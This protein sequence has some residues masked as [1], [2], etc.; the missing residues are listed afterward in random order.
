MRAGGVSVICFV[1]AGTFG[2]H[3]PSSTPTDSVTTLVPVLRIV[4][5]LE[6]GPHPGVE[7]GADVTF[8]RETRRTLA[9]PLAA[10]ATATLDATMPRPAYRIPVPPE[11]RGWG[12]VEIVRTILRGGKPFGLPPMAVDLARVAE[13][14]LPV[15]GLEHPPDEQIVT[16][17]GGA[18]PTALDVRTQP[19][20]VPADAVLAFGLGAEVLTPRVSTPLRARITAE[21]EQS[22]R[23]L[24]TDTVTQAF[25]WR[26]IRVPLAS[27]AG[28]RVRLRF[29]ANPAL[30]ASG[31]RAL[32]AEPLV[33]VPRRVPAMPVNVVLVSMD[34]LRARSVGVYGSERPT[35]PTIDAFAREGVLF[36]N[37]FSTA[38]FT[39][40]GHMSLFTGLWFRTH[41]V[42]RPSN[43]LPVERRTLP[44]MLQSAGYATAAFTSG[45]WV[46][47][48]CGFR[49]GFDTYH[50]QAWERV[51][52]LDPPGGI[53]FDAFT[54]GLD[55]IRANADRPFFLFLH[56]YQVHRPYLPPKPYNALFVGV[57][58]P[59]TQPQRLQL[60]YE[61]EVRYADDQVRALLEGLDA[62]GLRER[63]LVVLTADHGEA[64]GEHGVFEH[65]FDVHDELARVPLVMRLPGW[66]R[67]GAVVA[68]PVSLADV[69]PTVVDVLGQAPLPNADGTSLVP[70]LTGAAS[71]LPRA[72]VFTESE[73]EPGLE[74]VDLVAARTRTHTCIDAMRTGALE[75]FD[76]RIDPWETGVPAV[77][78]DATDDIR[79]TGALARS[80]ADAT[81]PVSAGD[82]PATTLVDDRSI[83]SDR[84]QQL[85]ELGYLE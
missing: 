23:T 45:G 67:A 64:F 26:D 38:A 83:G 48:A 8:D 74:W 63:T 36:T 56:S 54:R 71:R 58:P 34:T 32:F 42:F 60:A 50:E 22:S 57:A 46:V 82:Q 11:A 13:P 85:H 47:P 79:V 3:D 25:G 70:L 24:W 52:Q 55:W 69:A 49:R 84:E 44:E 76:R 66:I 28:H 75:C 17:Y 62:L 27:V 59:M 72:A 1:V 30:G 68:E 31:L 41:R 10:L 19:F 9:S 80:F 35:T 53:P 18:D 14:V 40:P 5:A 20:L 21:D 7:H 78:D 51:F 65:T 73:S 12:R 37:A 81:P 6:P 77:A 39:L 61:Q 16:M 4:E 2:C 29:S 15:G 43:V 33:L